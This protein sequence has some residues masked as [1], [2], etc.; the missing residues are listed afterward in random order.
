ML[1]T[2]V[3]QTESQGTQNLGMDSSGEGGRKRGR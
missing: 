2:G 1:E 3:D